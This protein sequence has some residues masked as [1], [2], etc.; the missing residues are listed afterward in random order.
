MGRER[1]MNP[2]AAL[3]LTSLLIGCS[4]PAEKAEAD[5]KFLQDH[6]GTAWEICHAAQRATQA[7]MDDH[8]AERFEDSRLRRNIYCQKAELDDMIIG[9][10]IRR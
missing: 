3:G 1:I 8:N 10:P 5:L 4:S 6:G 7:W 2:A 9:G